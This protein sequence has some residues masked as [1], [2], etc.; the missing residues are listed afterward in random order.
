MPDPQQPVLAC[1]ALGANLGDREATLRAALAALAESGA[2][3]VL[4]TSALHETDAVTLPGAPSQP[5]YLNAAAVIETTL[6][7]E[8]LLDL[9]LEIERA[10]GRD[11]A[12]AA[13]WTAR[14]IDLDLLL[15]AD[16]VIDAPGLRVP[17]P[18]LHERRFVL[19]P[20]AEV[21]PD[22][23]N[24]ERGV[25]VRAM[26]RALDAPGA[27]RRSPALVGVAALGLLVGG[28]GA[29]A[30]GGPVRDPDAVREPD[31]GRILAPAEALARMQ[32]AYLAGPVGEHIEL[33][34][35]SSGVVQRD[36]I[37]LRMA[38][39]TIRIDFDG[40]TAQATESGLTIAHETSGRAHTIDASPGES[41][42]ALL[43]R[44]LP[45]LPLP[46]L[47]I[48][49]RGAEATALGALCRD[50]RWFSATPMDGLLLVEGVGPECS[51]SIALDRTTW[52]LA[53]A[54]LRGRGAGGPISVEIRVEPFDPGA[55]DVWMLDAATLT[56][57]AS[58]A[59]LAPRSGDIAI[60]D[61]APDLLLLTR[62]AMPWRLTDAIGDG[63][64][65]LILFREDT[66]GAREALEAARQIGG[67][68]P[69]VGVA[70]GVVLPA[71]GVEPLARL[72]DLA[73]D[74]GDDLHWTVSADT[75]LGRFA[76]DSVGVLVAID[77]AGVVRLVEPIEN[78][79]GDGES[80]AR[81]V[82]DALGLEAGATDSQ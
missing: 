8:P 21:A 55:P 3:R 59:D 74:W 1:I 72:A 80:L 67:A 12:G 76:P 9:L 51:A 61:A 70:L 23:I 27:A 19:A 47:T 24:P 20:L 30:Q 48:A 42:F 40:L 43:E 49:R 15:Y 69:G 54:T 4:R 79:A 44:A 33:V 52:R 39:E 77:G 71:T 68:H 53:S 5:A 10:L 38:P 32:A 37:T 26:H 73:R 50:L 41:R 60:G 75:T 62:N 14:T 25:T 46:E 7:P 78:R 13:R 81:R 65:V 64:A 56:P 22:W 29:I 31:G 57:V 16:R 6:D 35:R 82:R 11:R 63:G 28:A 58:L 36:R 2:V 17:H 18:R 34:A 45:P 66:P